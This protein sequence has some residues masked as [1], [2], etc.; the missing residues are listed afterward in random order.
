MTPYN[1][2]GVIMV[3]VSSTQQVLN[4]G[5]VQPLHI[6]SVLH[7]SHLCLHLGEGVDQSPKYVALTQIP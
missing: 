3:M 5:H 4:Y 6:H 2:D 1:Y 7:C